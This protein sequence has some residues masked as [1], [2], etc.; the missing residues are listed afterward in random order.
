MK[1]I[2]LLFTGIVLTALISVVKA[3]TSFSRGVNL[4]GWFQTS[5]AHNIQF[6]KYTK[7]DFVN[8]KNLGCDVIRLPVNLFYMTDGNPD[9][10][11]DP[12]FYDFWIRR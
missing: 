2:A 12:L 11:V 1:K 9:Y 10:T 3:Q 5:S 8:I 6:S 7:K 4:T